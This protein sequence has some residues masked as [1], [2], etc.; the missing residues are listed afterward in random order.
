MKPVNGRNA[1]V[2]KASAE[3]RDNTFWRG[4]RRRRCFHALCAITVKTCVCVCVCVCVSLSV[5]TSASVHT[6]AKG[7]LA[8]ATAGPSTPPVDKLGPRVGPVIIEGCASRG[9]TA[10][11]RT[12][13]RPILLVLI[14][15]ND[16]Q[17]NV[18][19]PPSRWSPGSDSDWGV[20]QPP[21]QQ[22]LSGT[23]RRE[24]RRFTTPA[25]IYIQ[26][27]H[28]RTQLKKKCV[29]GT[30]RRPAF[31]WLD[32][33]QSVRAVSELLSQVDLMRLSHN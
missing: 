17:G 8:A 20:L 33:D 15:S 11:T 14:I 6:A 13:S 10:S 5:S 27:C 26:R 29:N 12:L 7:H 19:F 16:S 30:D 32:S 21:Q 3:P 25:P 23:D 22:S 24:A 2:P 1:T 4:R 9:A 28:P 18:V 31:R